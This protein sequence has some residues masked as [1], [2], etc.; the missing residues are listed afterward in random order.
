MKISAAFAVAAVLGLSGCVST[1]RSY[2]ANGN[3]L[4]RCE[5]ERDLFFGGA[6]CTGSSN[7]K[8]Q[9]IAPADLAA[10][11]QARDAAIKDLVEQGQAQPPAYH[12]T[13]K[14]DPNSS[15]KCPEGQV[16]QYGQ[17]YPLNPINK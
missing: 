12:S 7:P 17:C 13:I 15:V 1:T 9:G 16:Y 8:D 10:V 6:I 3:L 11:R 4:G 2:D 5:A 14:P